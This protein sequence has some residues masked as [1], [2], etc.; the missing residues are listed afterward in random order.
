M[1]ALA[2][3]TAT[4]DVYAAA[5]DA[6][7][8]GS[9]NF[10]GKDLA[11]YTAAKAYHLRRLGETLARP[12]SEC[13]VLDVGCGVGHLDQLLAPHVGRLVGVDV[14][15]GMVEQAARRNPGSEF[16]TYSGGRLPFEDGS[17]DLAFAVCVMHHVEPRQWD[18]FVAEMWRAVRP[19]G[20]VAVIEHNPIN[21]LTRRSVAACAFDDDAALLGPRRVT[22]ALRAAGSSKARTRYILFAPFGGDR[23]RAAE[24][25]V[26]WL[27]LG[28]QYMVEAAR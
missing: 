8:D 22:R 19:G 26:A 14:S 9:V 24:A 11:F 23:W 3:E 28:A 12:L 1:S 2:A 17:F 20:A 7:V 5:Y 18:A 27:P 16:A 25:G 13:A 15:P 6:I 10:T 4:F 21:P